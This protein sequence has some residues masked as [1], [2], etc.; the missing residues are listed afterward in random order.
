MGNPEG[1]MSDQIQPYVHEPPMETQ[2][3]E[4]P[5]LKVW[6]TVARRWRMIVLLW[7][8]LAIPAVAGVWHMVEPTYTATAQVEVK[9]VLG[10][11]LWEDESGIPFFD[12]YLNTQAELISS[13]QVLNTAL[14]D[15]NLRGHPFLEQPDPL[16]ALRG[17]MK[18]GSI[19]RT[20]LLQINVERDDPDTAV[21]LARAVTAAY[22]ARVVAKE[23]EEER[24]RMRILERERDQLR[25]Q[26]VSQR[27]EKNRL[28]EAYG[29]A[30]ETMFDALR[31][32]VT[33]YSIETRLELERTEL[34][35]LNLR[36]QLA[37]LDEERPVRRIETA[38]REQIIES[39]PVVQ[40][41]QAE[42]TTIVARMIRSGATLR[43]EEQKERLETELQKERERAA[44]E[45]ER[46]LA[47]RR[48]M[49]LEEERARLNAELTTAE[50]RRDMLL[51]RATEQD[52]KGLAIG[53]RGLEI[54]MLQEQIE[55]TRQD[56]DRVNE[57]IKQ[58]E[59]ESRRRPGRISVVS[60]AEIRPDGIEDKRKKLLP[61]AV[62]GTLF[63][64]LGLAFLRN[65]LDPLVHSSEQIEQ[66]MG[67]HLLGTLPSLHELRSGL[68]SEEDFRESYR[69][70]IATLGSLGRDGRVPGS[71]LV[72][73]AQ[74]CEGKTSLAVSLAACLAETGER[75][76][77]I[78]G[79]VQA[80]QIRQVLK[81][82]PPSC[83]RGVLLGQHSLAES[84]EHS[85]VRGLDVLVSGTNGDS[86]RE[87]LNSHSAGKLL[88][89]ASG[90][91]DHVVI[92]SPPV[93]GAADALV[94]ARAV[95]GV[96]ISSF[97]GYSNLKI[98]R[99]AY[100]RLTS[101]G[102]NILGAVAC[103]VSVRESY[104]SQSYMS[105]REMTSGRSPRRGSG[106][107]R[108]APYVQLP[109]AEA[110]TSDASTE[111]HSPG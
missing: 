54:A 51:E 64:A 32:S 53:R 93:L 78:D 29:T 104:Q 75:V 94:W 44:A 26:L 52:A 31:E 98:M 11:I 49:L 27:D 42:L 20:H 73:S 88:T 110:S 38:E 67:L 79:D 58:L 21:R 24:E 71:I 35:I 85:N 15:P 43:D 82:N 1:L 77:L 91:Y 102:A 96:I 14:A 63:L 56:F 41:L 3:Q 81:L 36:E 90:L 50:R 37:R 83:L 84:V 25:A 92:D 107:Q 74:P 40:S 111:S 5:L 46:R 70:V 61:V 69:M 100:R 34:E 65:Q 97:A 18:V 47:D 7:P 17:S 6:T 39:D 12:A 99:Q 106:Q 8:V 89:T 86:A 2:Q 55:T 76:L 23:A 66:D 57:R 33:R 87:L 9:P 95:E 45:A 28:A 72:T 13:H 60:V 59:L 80:P 4:S 103:N 105:S 22:E 109:A 48:P 101:V 62:A 68:I 19:P 10:S 108:T 16:G 30:S